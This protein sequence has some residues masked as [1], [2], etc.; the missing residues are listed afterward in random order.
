MDAAVADLAKYWWSGCLHWLC[1]IVLI[2]VATWL[3]GIF[4]G[5]SWNREV[6]SSP[7]RAV[8]TG[9]GSWEAAEAWAVSQSTYWGTW[10]G[11]V[12]GQVVWMNYL[13]CFLEVVVISVTREEEKGRRLVLGWPVYRQNSIYFPCDL[14]GDVG[15]TS[16]VSQRLPAYYSCDCTYLHLE[17]PACFYCGGR[18]R[19]GTVLWPPE[20]SQVTLW[21]S[22]EIKSNECKQILDETGLNGGKKKK[23]LTRA[24]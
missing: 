22:N 10:R 7:N 15:H 8:G 13:L 1:D 14:S 5:V 12:R 23:N 21:Y 2:A 6:C 4:L 9:D 3:I 18:W 20:A 19:L 16:A 11:G 17:T 24:E